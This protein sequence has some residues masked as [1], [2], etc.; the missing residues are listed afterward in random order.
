MT[1]RQ[2]GIKARK[3]MIKALAVW[4]AILL[5]ASPGLVMAEHGNRAVG[6]Q[7]PRTV[8]VFLVDETGSYH[9]RNQALGVAQGII[10]RLRPGDTFYLRRLTDSS[11]QESCHVLRFDAPAGCQS[12]TNKFDTKAMLAHQR[13]TKEANL[14]KA[15]AM[16]EVNALEPMKSSRS[17]FYGGIFAAGERLQTEGRPGDRKLL[18]IGG[19]ME[20]NVG[21]NVSPGLKG[22]EV[23][24]VMWE[25]D[26]DPA[27]AN[28][29]K[30]QWTDYLVTRC[31]A[32]GVRFLPPDMKIEF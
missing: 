29:L 13:C 20:D 16:A 12:P 23:L 25:A 1:V 32:Q 19:D 22:V 10:A 15:R 6:I 4:L 7:S 11:Y 24:V 26:G 21:R 27:K 14:R 5:T 3:I 18:V 17:D 30:Q 9:H 31:G 28:K 2:P 8:I